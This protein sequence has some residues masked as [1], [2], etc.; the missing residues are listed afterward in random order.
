MTEIFV[1]KDIM[2]R[3]KAVTRGEARRKLSNGYVGTQ[4]QV[5]DVL[6]NLYW[7]AF[8]FSIISKEKIRHEIVEYF[9]YINSI[10][11]IP[12]PELEV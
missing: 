9:N 12:I 5:G 4:F 7:M 6:I 2:N 1:E 11:G 10:T 3:Y 8:S